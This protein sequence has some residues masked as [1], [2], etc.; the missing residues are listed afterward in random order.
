MTINKPNTTLSMFSAVLS[1]YRLHCIYILNKQINKQIHKCMPLW[2]TVNIA[3]SEYLCSSYSQPLKRQLFPDMVIDLILTRS[4]GLN[5]NTGVE[6]FIVND[7][8][9]C[10]KYISPHLRLLYSRF[11][12]IMN[13][14]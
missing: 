8:G 3:G 13:I 9:L 5:Y 7:G 6:L 4:L 10:I 2:Y 1:M 14:I 12:H 11:N